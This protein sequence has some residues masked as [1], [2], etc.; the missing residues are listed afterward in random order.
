MSKQTKTALDPVEIEQ[1]ISVYHSE[2]RQLNYRVLSVRKKIA[3]LENT[4]SKQNILAT[5][6]V[7]ASKQPASTTY[8]NSR[9]FNFSSSIPGL[10][11]PKKDNIP[12]QMQVRRTRRLSF[13]D[14]MQITHIQTKGNALL[15]S[16]V[17]EHTGNGHEALVKAVIKQSHFSWYYFH[18]AIS[19]IIS[20]YPF[21]EIKKLLDRS[22]FSQRKN[23]RCRSEETLKTKRS[24]TACSLGYQLLEWEPKGVLSCRYTVVINQISY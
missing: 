2:L 10:R 7:A 8:S 20:W 22:I 21:R 15:S 1:L 11:T 4:L 18:S 12:D 17:L 16:E 24:I 13:W 14:E 23:R 19:D 3:Q 6:A 5:P 9:R